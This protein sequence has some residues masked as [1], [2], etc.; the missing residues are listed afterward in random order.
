[1][2]LAGDG[3]AVGLAQDGGAEAAGDLVR[4]GGCR[5]GSARGW[6]AGG[7]AI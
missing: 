6:D 1:V 4:R 3:G 2:E 5:V 7:L